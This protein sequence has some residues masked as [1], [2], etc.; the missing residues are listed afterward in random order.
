MIPGL[1]PGGRGFES[2]LSHFYTYLF[3]ICV[4]SIINSKNKTIT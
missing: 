2:P 3:M 4:G 1:G